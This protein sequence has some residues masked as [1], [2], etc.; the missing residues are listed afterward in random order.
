MVLEVAEFKDSLKHENLA[1]IEF[2]QA[3]STLNLE[4]NVADNWRKWKQR[5]QPFMEASGSMK[6]PEKQRVAIFLHVIGEEALEIYN[7]FS[8]STAEQKLDVLF[9][10]FEDYCN[11]RRN[12]T[13]E[14]HKFLTC[15][16]E[17]TESI[18]QYVTE[19]RTK[20]STCE[21]GELCESLI[22][23]RI[24]CG[25]SCNT[26]RETLLQETD[27]S[28]QKPI[29]MCRASEFSKRQTKSI[30]E[31]SK[32]VDFVNKNATRDGKFPPK[33]KK[34]KDR[35]KM[36]KSGPPNSC[37]RCGTVHAPRKCPAFGKICQKCK[38]RNHFASQCLSKNVH[39]VESDQAAQPFVEDE[40]LEELFIGQVQ[41]DDHKQEWKASLQVNNNLVEFKLDTGA[42][43]N[44]IPSDVFNSLKG[45]PQLK[46]TKAKL[47][48]FNGSEIPVAGVARMIC[49]YK[50]KQ[51]DSDFFVVEAEGQPPL[52][53]LRACQ[54]LNLI[55]FVRTVDTA[56]VNNVNAESS[57]LN[58]FYDLFEG[59][60][61][62]EGEHHIEINPE[63]KPVIHPP[64]KVPFT[65]LPKL[66]RMEQLGAIEKVDQPTEW[67]NSIVI[68]EKPDGNLRICLDPKDLNRAVKR[69]HFQLPTST[70]ITSKL[71]GAKVFSKLDAKDGFWHVKLDH[72]SSL[73][74]TFNT[75]FGRFKFNRLPF[76]LNSSNEVFQK[77]MQF[78]FEGIEGVE[79]IYDDLLVWGKDE[80]SHD[81][82]LRN[83]LER[84]REKGVKLKK[85]KCEIKIPEVVYIGD[86][87]T[88]DGVKPDE[89]KIEAILNLPSP[90][91][92][93]DVE[94]LLGMLTYLSK[95]IP[96]MSTLT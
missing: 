55:K 94:R 82:A 9:Q 64:R 79:V 83:V 10:K 87:I 35:Q 52:L 24:V 25:I 4:K 61:E 19:L 39:F 44:V 29:D 36:T 42:Q 65:L 11:P 13:F 53:G 62:L 33:E 92:K 90:Q 60:G 72:P 51:I 27:L 63:V 1:Q 8:L 48:G 71:T 66:E 41:K 12:I 75:P 56:D 57:I 30:T 46:T 59:L 18:D 58:E 93:K 77:K 26:L 34:E 7:T 89:S 23:D 6:K 70:E 14:R 91:N 32:S 76:G 68:V 31:E 84:A 22:R 54:E 37:K 80:E 47:T 38:N 73:L 95:F 28:L 3:A 40:Q 2:I 49:K 15:V 50:D 81:R 86:K 21:F 67:V 16:Q 20:A 74:T 5:L 88:K 96:N 45:M 85:Q 17:P 43:A 69:E 78:V